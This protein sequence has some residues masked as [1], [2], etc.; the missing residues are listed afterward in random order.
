LILYG[1][2][3]FAFK[4]ED[5][6]RTLGAY[7]D[8]ARRGGTDAARNLLIALGQIEQALADRSLNISA[9]MDATDLAADF[10]LSPST[11]AAVLGAARDALHR[12]LTPASN[13]P[14]KLPEGF[15]FYSLYPEQYIEAA[16]R[17]CATRPRGPVLIIGIRSIGTTLSAIVAAALRADG[18]PARRI[19][20]RPTGHP[21]D[22]HVDLNL[23]SFPVAAIV[24]D[25]GPGLS[26]SS[27]AAVARAFAPAASPTSP[28]F[29][30]TR[31][32][33]APR[34]L[35]KSAGF[36]PKRQS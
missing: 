19:T 14:I 2:P 7:F 1:D 13:L 35:P 18:W 36:G 21:L 28:S 8:A 6:A 32:H 3:Q 10:F 24:V 4:A 33:P 17:W 29:P 27:M 5:A 15:A 9:A 12:S 30:V 20:V 31:I 34:P 25:E 23:N 11:A 16:R 26:G 22:R